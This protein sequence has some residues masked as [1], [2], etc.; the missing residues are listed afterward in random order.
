MSNDNPLYDQQQIVDFLKQVGGFSL[1][2]QASLEEAA[3]KVVITTYKRGALIIKQ[4]EL[5][6]DLHVIVKGSVQ[7]PLGTQ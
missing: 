1:A 5:G 3:S 7:V 6:N 4:G 2:E